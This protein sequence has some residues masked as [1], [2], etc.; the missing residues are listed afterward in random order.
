M[1]TFVQIIFG[2]GLVGALLNSTPKW[3]HIQGAFSTA[4]I[5]TAAPSLTRRLIT[6]DSGSHLDGSD[7]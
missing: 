3:M 7:T 5:L 6:G 1:N 4:L 2:V